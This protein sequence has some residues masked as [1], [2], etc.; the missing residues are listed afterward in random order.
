M[1][2][3]RSAP[4]ASAGAPRSQTWLL[5]ATVVV[6]LVSLVGADWPEEQ[7]LQ[8]VPTFAAI[9]LLAFA[10]RGGWLS[11]ESLACVV[12]FLWLHILG[13][14][15]IYS[16]VPYDDWARSLCGSTVSSWLGWER[17]HYDRLVHLCFG[18]LAIAPARE[19]ARRYGGMSRAWA[20]LFAWCAVMT[21][22]GGYEVV[23]WLLTLLLSPDDA[24]AYNGQ[25]GDAWDAQKDMALAMLGSLACLATCGVWDR[26][27]RAKQGRD[28]AA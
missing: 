25:Q 6:L 26:R 5:L 8:H 10:V 9:L 15:Y 11:T 20:N 28:V 1:R 24:E 23:E 7:A 3:Q 2:T 22:S 12:A 27:R 21:I 16:F 14:R 18:A 19:L 4:L 13:A 17:N